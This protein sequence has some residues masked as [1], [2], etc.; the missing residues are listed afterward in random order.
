M[1]DELLS[2]HAVTFDGAFIC[3]EDGGK[4]RSITNA[5][6]DVIR[7]LETALAAHGLDLVDR[8]AVIYRDTM[9]NWDQLLTRDGHF[10][11]FKSLGGTADLETAK[12]RA[13]VPL[14]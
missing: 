2:G 14:S 7:H 11:G 8:Y 13:S 12:A 4:G 10:A 6:E 1:F 3:L 9:G 5:A